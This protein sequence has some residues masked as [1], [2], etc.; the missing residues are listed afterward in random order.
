M[1]LTSDLNHP[2][3]IQLSLEYRFGI[4]CLYH[5][6]LQRSKLIV[7]AS[8]RWFGPETQIMCHVSYFHAFGP[9]FR[10]SVPSF[11]VDKKNID[12]VGDSPGVSMLAGPIFLLIV[13][14]SLLRRMLVY[15][16]Q[17]W[18]KLFASNSEHMVIIKVIPMTERIASSQSKEPS[19]AIKKTDSQNFQRHASVAQG[20]FCLF[21]L[22]E[23]PFVLVIN[24]LY[25]PLDVV[26]DALAQGAE[27]IGLI[28]NEDHQVLGNKQ[29]LEEDAS[30]YTRVD[31]DGVEFSHEESSHFVPR[32]NIEPNKADPEEVADLDLNQLPTSASKAI[33][34]SI[35][36]I[37]SLSYKTFVHTVNF[38]ASKD[39]SD[40]EALPLGV[41]SLHLD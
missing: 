17:I 9:S 6:S 28:Q 41:S 24:L 19:D 3:I 33:V 10:L 40:Y 8:F 11:V 34:S 15:L 13:P 27:G 23:F 14:P 21:S 25:F 38:P 35:I 31:D 4:E 12:L 20:G 5:K 2:L 1:L 30:G 7:T 16:H 37:L 22:K 29:K 32:A 36:L 39:L 18:T 26:K